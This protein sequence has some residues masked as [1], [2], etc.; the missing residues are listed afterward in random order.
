M[1]ANF[2]NKTKPVTVFTIVLLLFLYYSFGCIKNNFEFFSVIYFIKKTVIFS[3]FILFL[4]IFKFIIK[5]NKLTKD[6]SY[7]LLLV[8]LFLGTFSEAIFSNPIFFSNLILLLSIRK[9]YPLRSGIN[10][11]LK[12]FDAAFWIGIST[13]L[14]SWSIFYIFLIYVAMLIYKKVSLKNLLIPII[15]LVTPLFI[16]GTY[17]FYFDKLPIF[18]DRFNY[19]ISLNFEAYNSLKFIIP[20]SFLVIMLLGSLVILTPKIVTISNNLKFSWNVLINHLLI[21]ILIVIMSPIKN[22]SELF[23]I[24][25]PATIIIANFIQKTESV[26]L[27]NVLLYLFLILSISVYFL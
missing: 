27:K 3:L 12:L 20:I 4:L 5:K 15:G 21:S 1:I 10:T 23:F 2:F 8:V 17:C 6:N 25:F 22:G 18:Y 11:K 7:A 26:I 24:I 13:L 9:I 14:Y 16:Y 19:N